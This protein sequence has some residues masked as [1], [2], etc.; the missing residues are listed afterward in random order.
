MGLFQNIVQGSCCPWVAL[1]SHDISP[2]PKS[3]L[4][5]GF[6]A[7][8][9]PGRSESRMLVLSFFP[10][11]I[12]HCFPGGS[13][14]KANHIAMADSRVKFFTWLVRRRELDTLLGTYDIC[15]CWPSREKKD[16]N[17]SVMCTDVEN[18]Q[19]VKKDR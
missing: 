10:F 3:H 5:T 13:L 16:L 7:S 6:A 11:P 8:G 4:H 19:S 9:K 1:A 2:V 14:V 18:S 12:S 15:Y 17:M